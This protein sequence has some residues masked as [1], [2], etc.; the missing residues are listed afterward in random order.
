MSITVFL[1][2]KLE[3]K[4]FQLLHYIAHSTIFTVE[5]ELVSILNR[6][7]GPMELSLYRQSASAFKVFIYL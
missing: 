7:L 1:S 5:L 4:R 6:P 3:K 2:Y